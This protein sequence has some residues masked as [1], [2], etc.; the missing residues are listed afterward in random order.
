MFYAQYT[1]VVRAALIAMGAAGLAMPLMAQ[2][3]PSTDD[4]T[5]AD[6][7]LSTVTV[8]GTVDELQSLDF[9][10]PN[11]SA[12]IRKDEIDALG[13]RKL[14]QALQYQAGVLSEPFGAD[15]KVEWFKIRGFDASVSLDGTPTSPNGYFVW[16]PEV[17][18]V[19]SVEVL[20][21]PSALVFGASE[22][23]GVVNLVTKRPQKQRALELNT[24]VGN[25]NR[26]GLS[27]D[28]NNIANSDGSVYYRLVAQARKE[29]GMQRETNMKSYY[30]APSVTMEFSPR[31]SLTLLGSIQ[32]EDGRPTNG[33]LPAYG[34]IIDTPYG[35]IDRRLNAGEPGVDQLRRTQSSLGWLL[36]HQFNQDWKFTQ[37]YKYTNLDLDQTNTFAYGSN[38]DREL[39]RGYTYTDGK[40][41]TH[42]LDNRISGRL[43]LGDS[44]QLLPTFGIDYLKSDTDGLNNGFGAVPNLD[45]FNPVY[46]APFDV[47][48]TPY[49]L[50]SKQWGAYA[51]TQMRVG[52]H[53]NFNAGIRHD[54]A[55][56]N[57]RTNG[58]DS[59]YDVS[60]NSIN[61]GAMYITDF[62]VS[63]YI[64]YSE[65]FK[66]VDGVDGYGNAYR[67]YEGQQSEMGVKLEP[68]WLNGGNI[69]L[70][71]FDVKE[72]NALVSDASNIQ[73]QTG[74]RTNKGIELQGDFKLGTNTR[75]KAAYTHNNS[76]QD[77]TA[78]Q[79]VRTPLI[80][81][82]Q[83]SLWVSHA[84]ALANSQKLTVAAGARYNGSTE[85]QR[86]TPGT[87][88]SGYTLLDLMVRYDI[89]REWA[90]QFN[91]RNLTDKTYVSGCDF[92]CYYG[93]ARTVDLQL[94]YKWK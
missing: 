12:V 30:L 4:T 62:G 54:K 2:T 88:I 68:T 24:E 44:V 35:R 78:T 66:P 51:S 75:I 82:N 92:Y 47:T 28:Y 94:Q 84:F 89:S 61:A 41:K 39:R 32:R 46:G 17:F 69:T 37:N 56:N 57:G 80:P 70:A 15:N 23:G 71:Y 90:L 93:G 59:G 91:A 31:T 16:K 53:W 49:G 55:K 9:Y 6:K 48:G 65:S 38:G 76:R 18:G 22:T 77:V 27:V 5:A 33:F 42:Y 25:N 19:E 86:Y 7:T 10:A 52:S 20:K 81:D 63:P 79:T 87:R 50:H 14:D 3:A 67:P 58:A 11:S 74:K 64:S 83:A 26:L 73:S 60:K 29:D 85:D 40:A 72:K 34:I 1:P 13:A 21:G 45:M 36:S 8:V 43:R